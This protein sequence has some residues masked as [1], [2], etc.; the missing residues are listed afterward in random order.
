MNI[1]VLGAAGGFGAAMVEDA[2]ARGHSVVAVARD[3]GRV[4]RKFGSNANLTIS[5]EDILKPG[6]ISA[7]AQSADAVIF[8]VNVAYEKWEPFMETA[9]K[10]T[11]EGLSTLES[12]PPLVFPGNV[13]ALGP[14]TGEAFDESAPNRPS[15]RKGRVRARMEQMLE[16]APGNRC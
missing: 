12:K 8:A 15:T 14:Q 16:A 2:L 13:Y 3:A 7:L 11:L 4:T 6:T 1:L 9:L 10:T 5:G